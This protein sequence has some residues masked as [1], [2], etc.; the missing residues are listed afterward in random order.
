MYKALFMYNFIKN[1]DWPASSR[2]GDFVIAVYGNSP[3][4][5]ELIKVSKQRKV[6]N[7]NISIV[8]YA[9]A[10]GIGNCQVIYLP[11]AKSADLERVMTKLS[12]K[13]T[14]IVCDKEGTIQRGAC[15]NFITVNGDQKF[16]ISKNNIHGKGLAV[17]NYLLNLGVVVE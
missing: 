3:M 8:K 4:Y 16:A 14:L 5:E 2:Q 12:G 15:I 6:G 9:S 11:S 7:Q 1:I 10:D 13:A 17:N